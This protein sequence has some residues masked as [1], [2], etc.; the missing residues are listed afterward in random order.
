MNTL[1]HRKSA[2][3]LRPRGL[4]ITGTDTGVGKTAVTAALAQR[5][6][7]EMPRVAALK[8]IVSGMEASGQWTDVEI[9]R[10]ASTPPRSFAETCLY[11]LDP[12]IAP[13]WAAAQAGLVLNRSQIH[14]FIQSQ[15]ASMDAVLVEGAGGFLVPLGEDWGFADL[16]RDLQFPVL[17]VVGLRL[18]AIN[19]ALLSV[20]AIIAR[21]LPMAGWVANHLQTDLA[22]GTLETL[23]RLM[24]IPCLGE[25]PF[26][27]A[28]SSAWRSQFL[29][30]P[31]EWY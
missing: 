21:G 25:I 20:E 8:P 5:C 4:F 3:G 13:H 6:R 10:A 16:A 14:Q 30:L 26:Q 11:A 12:P 22:P 9:L 29:S 1:P 19:H 2:S 23:Q 28:A 17:L 18:G 15:S 27:A 31:T 24:P 7:K